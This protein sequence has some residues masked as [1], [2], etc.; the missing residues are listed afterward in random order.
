MRAPSH[1]H[2][3]LTGTLTSVVVCKRTPNRPR[4]LTSSVVCLRMP[5]HRQRS[6]SMRR[7]GF[8]AILCIFLAHL[9]IQSPITFNCIDI[10]FLLYLTDVKCTLID[11]A[12]RNHQKS[13]S[14]RLQ[15]WIIIFW[16]PN[17][18]QMYW[19]RIKSTR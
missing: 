12:A 2:R 18:A 1:R 8:L 19:T 13:T 10:L 5:S 4:T 3:A 7:K 14:L 15:G 9:S 17:V 16:P 11:F 6:R